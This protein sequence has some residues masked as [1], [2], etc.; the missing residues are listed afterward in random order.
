MMQCLIKHYEY[1]KLQ[2]YQTTKS[3]SDK[4][5]TTFLNGPLISI[6]LH[7]KI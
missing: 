1:K 7:T 5:I 6:T 3:F 4:N 2:F